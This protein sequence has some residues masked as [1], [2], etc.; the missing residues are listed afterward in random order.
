[1]KRKISL[2]LVIAMMTSFTLGGCNSKSGTKANED[3]DVIKI[4]VFEPMTG[5]NAALKIAD[6]G[7]IMETGRIT[8]SGSGQELLSNDEIK[9][10]YLGEAL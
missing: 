6:I 8:L 10:A 9:K 3:S 4:G 5:A 1:M 7:Y 2:L